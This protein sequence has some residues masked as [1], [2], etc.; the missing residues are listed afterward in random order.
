LEDVG[1][2]GSD[3]FRMSRAGRDTKFI[4]TLNKIRGQGKH[5]AANFNLNKT[6]V[7]SGGWPPG[8]CRVVRYGGP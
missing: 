3:T 4:I 7:W 1:R 2:N 6:V 8:G 5:S